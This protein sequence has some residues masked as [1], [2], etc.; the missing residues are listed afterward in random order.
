MSTPVPEAKFDHLLRL[1]D[2]RGT[3]A[4]ARLGQPAPDRGYYTDDM[5]RV[6]VVATREPGPDGEL[7]ALAGIALRFLAD[8]QS[9]DGP[10]RNHM[11]SRGIW[12]DEPTVQDCWG[13]CL[14][15]LGTAAAHSNVGRVRQMAIIQFERAAQK[16]S[17]W[18]RAQAFAA[19]GAA[20]MLSFDP[21]HAPARTLLV[22]Y[23]AGLAESSGDLR[24]PWPEPRLT[25]ANAVLAEA[26]I[27]AGTALEDP[28]V[29]RRGLDLLAWLVEFET[30]DGHLSPTPAAGRGPQDARPGFDQQPA[31]VAALADACARAARVDDDPVWVD[32][33]NAALAW[34]CGAN[35]IGEPM[36]DPDTGAGYDGLCTDGVDVNQGA[37]STLAVL[38]ILQQARRLSVMPG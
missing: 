14:W 12:L 33:V 31:E 9:F 32:G 8:A 26:M 37:E 30:R 1:T 28:A 22:D 20:E 19:V 21:V 15:A 16:R 6:L 35:D 24:W 23:V 18:L 17:P 36:W 2:R 4:N 3:V 5:A 13:R 11:D 25:Y 34:V 27:A 29:R 10:C 38:S 7:N